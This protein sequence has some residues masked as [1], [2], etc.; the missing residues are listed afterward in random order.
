[1]GPR[2]PGTSLIFYG[3]DGCKGGWLVARSSKSR[4]GLLHPEFFVCRD[5]RSI[6]TEAEAGRAIVAIDIPIG[7]PDECGRQCDIEARKIL[8]AA[9]KS[10]VFPVPMRSALACSNYAA[11]C[12][13][14]HETSGQRLSRQTFGILPKIR[15]VDELITPALQS[16]VRESHPEVTFALIGDAGDVGKKK[17]AEGC[18]RRLALLAR[19][20][21]ALTMPGIQS[22]RSRAG[23]RLVKADDVIDAAACLL[24][25]SR[26]AKGKARSFPESLL[27]DSRGLKMEIVC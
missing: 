20:G 25:A 14:N 21:I 18:T 9:R 15:D 12:T 24:T 16:F 7:L 23:R 3:I 27:K 17:D 10:A 2:S 1:M 8:S 4:N 19:Q 6:F 22:V 5:L 13:L 26:I 11:A